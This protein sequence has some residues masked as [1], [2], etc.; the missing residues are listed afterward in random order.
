MLAKV[1]ID[2]EHRGVYIIHCFTLLNLVSFIYVETE[3]GRLQRVRVGH[4]RIV[5]TN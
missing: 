4:K 5:N 2:C 1:A 3:Q